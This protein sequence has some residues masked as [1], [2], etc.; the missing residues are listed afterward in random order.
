[1]YEQT[2]Y[3]EAKKR[4]EAIRGFYLHLV[5]YLVVNAALVIINLLTDPEYL[6]F[7]WLSSDGVLVLYFTLFP[8]SAV[9]GESRGKSERSK[10]SWRGINRL[11]LVELRRFEPYQARAVDGGQNRL[12]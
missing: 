12:L 8:Y 7:V 10:S 9:C 6:W 11:E 2:R 1:M 3:E 5:S 4:V